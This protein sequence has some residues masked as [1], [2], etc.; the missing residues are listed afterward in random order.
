[1][2]RVSEFVGGRLLMV[3]VVAGVLGL[4]LL[5]FAGL[6]LWLVVTRG[7]VGRDAVSLVIAGGLAFALLSISGSARRNGLRY[8]RGDKTVAGDFARFV[9]RRLERRRRARGR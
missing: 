9:A 5:L 6:K 1:M 2:G 4:G 3:W 7:T 8:L